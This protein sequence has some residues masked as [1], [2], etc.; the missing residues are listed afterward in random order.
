MGRLLIVLLIVLGLALYFPESRGRILERARPLATP[1][2]AWM[3]NQELRRIAE[4]LDVFQTS[5]GE[6]P[7]RRGEFDDWLDRRYPLEESRVDAWGTRYRLEVFSSRFEVL[8][9]GPDRSFRTDDD[10]IREGVR[11]AVSRSR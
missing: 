4:D 1:V 9:A 11:D 2:Y 8:S 6:L 7:T 5:R 3:T 10:L